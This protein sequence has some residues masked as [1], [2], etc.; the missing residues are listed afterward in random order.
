MQFSQLAEVL[1]GSL[2]GS[3]DFEVTELAPIDLATSTCVTFVLEGQFEK[4]VADSLLIIAE[5]QV[6]ELQNT[7][8]ILGDKS[9]EQKAM[10]DSQMDLL[11]QEIT[12]SK[13]QIN[14]YERLLKRERRKRI[15]TAV[16]GVLTTSAA[17]FLLISK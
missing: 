5:K 3:G 9:V 2:I 14:G 13:D 1:G 15:F 4:K 12:L 8:D 10:C 7:I 16:G 11:R 6:K 17:L